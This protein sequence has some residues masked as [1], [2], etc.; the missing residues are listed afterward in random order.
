MEQFFG[1]GPDN[2]LKASLSPD[3]ATR[4]IDQAVRPPQMTQ[5]ESWLSK[6]RPEGPKAEK[7]NSQQPRMAALS[8]NSF[9]PGDGLSSL[10]PKVLSSVVCLSGQY[11]QST[12]D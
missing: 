8:S 1:K 6:H 10:Y 11:F 12:R 3:H 7:Q 4:D 2:C 9:S 5:N